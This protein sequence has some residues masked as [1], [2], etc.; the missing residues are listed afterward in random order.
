MRGYTFFHPVRSGKSTRLQKFFHRFFLWMLF[1][2]L[3][4]SGISQTGIPYYSNFRLPEGISEKNHGLVQDSVGN[5]LFANNHGLL[6]FDGRNWEYLFQDIVPYAIAG[7]PKS[8]R[9]YMS[10]K[11]GFGTLHKTPQESWSYRQ[12]Y[13]TDTE[14]SQITSITF[15]NDLVYFYSEMGIYR[16][17][18]L[19]G[20][21]DEIRPAPG[22]SFAGYF[23]FGDQLFVNLRGKGLFISKNNEL[24]PFPEGRLFDNVSI[25]FFLEMSNDQCILVTDNSMI[26]HFNG[27]VFSDFVP[28]DD[29]Y[30]SN[31]VITRGLKV[32]ESEISLATLSGGCLFLNLKTGK[33]D[34]IMNYQ[35]GLPDDEIY[36]MNMDRDKGIWLTHEFGATRIDPGLP[37]R[38][39]NPL[40]GLEG[41]LSEA[42]LFNNQLY[43]STGEGVFY[44]HR[45]KKYKETEIL[46][47]QPS[48]NL[49]LL[50]NQYKPVG[51]QTF[52]PGQSATIPPPDSFSGKKKKGFL[53]GIFKSGK[54]TLKRLPEKSS[55]KKA[56]T[57]VSPA[58]QTTIENQPPQKERIR[59]R[60]KKQ[61]KLVS[62]SWE[63]SK[64][65]ELNT[66]CGQM[67]VF[68][69]RLFVASNT[70]LYEITGRERKVITSYAYV[71]RLARS[72][73]LPDR[74]YV[75]TESGLEAVNFEGKTYRVDHDFLPLQQ[76]VFSI[77]EDG[78]NLWLG[79][80][81]KVIMVPLD[82]D[83]NPGE[84]VIYQLP[85]PFSERV[86]IKKLMNH[87]TFFIPS[88]VFTFNRNTNMVIA[89]DSLRPVNGR[90]N[91][92]LFAGRKGVFFRSEK[93]WKRLSAKQST[94]QVSP[95]LNLFGD[96][97]FLRP[98]PDNNLWVINGNNYLYKILLDTI[99]S[100]S[101]H[102]SLTIRSFTGSEKDFTGIPSPSVHPGDQP[103]VLQLNAPSYIRPD[104]TEYRF[105]ITG[106]NPD[107]SAWTA[108]PIITL[109]FLSSGSYVLKIRARNSLGQ[110]SRE[111]IIPLNVLPPFTESAYFYILLVIGV[112]SVIFLVVVIRERKLIHDKKVLELKVKARTR[113]IEMQ[114]EQ[115]E[116]Q[117]NKIEKQ[118]DEI[119]FRKQEITDSIS[120]GKRIQSAVLPPT[121]TLDKLLPGYFIFYQPRDIVSGDFYWILEKNGKVAV[122]VVDCT[123]H[124]VPGAFM[125]FLGYS[126]LTEIGNSD[127]L[128]NAGKILDQLRL[129][130]KAALH[131]T[132]ENQ[133]TEDG[134]D[135]ALCILD[136]KEKSCRFAGAYNSLYLV[137][138]QIRKV[139]PGDKM[140]IG[141]HM[142]D[143]QPFTNHKLTLE[144]GDMLY[145]FTDG[146]A[147]Q[148]GGP[149][150]KKFKIEPFHDLILQI[151]KLDIKEQEKR[152]DEKLREWMGDADQ[153]DDILVM[154][155]RV[156]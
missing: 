115:I 104:L 143:D 136:F 30:L 151:S 79:S 33:T 32:S 31:A 114:K 20:T 135:M 13:E 100:V 131:Q 99:H 95:Y 154:G 17:H 89:V 35:S 101:N 91:K 3:F 116:G 40:K 53:S 94:E 48:K 144:K 15:H 9:I 41:N 106:L 23:L 29:N 60:I 124:G 42:I 134:M 97:K 105:A 16:Y 27:H 46:I 28:Q 58:P 69:N 82:R 133:E 44:L 128:S 93:G 10:T 139:F 14:H 54:K 121:G 21:T 37:V 22:D 4:F 141:M 12:L 24:V 138:D 149:R 45:V 77:L 146:Y 18:P 103:L 127:P 102:F 84:P 147:D 86:T 50:K 71:N 43:V 38:T 126:I 119:A 123:G 90:L 122:A 156:K 5:L 155:I 1:S 80:Y 111:K 7:D 72:P 74:M 148:F 112:L 62:E 129:K 68:K 25:L 73:S 117:K 137:R 130:L 39:F 108:N 120:Y 47:K 2:G 107:W 109:P 63:F 11:T 113:E 125:S 145:M 26:Y 52:Q 57:T 96:I 55:K 150:G 56:V 51:R 8:G 81:S 34:F 140:P 118:R 64:V 110:Q 67:L 76:P 70:G 153:V 152:L 83:N 61:V 78:Q 85:S 36:A 59:Y 87:I 19:Q 66:K 98:G 75:G 65:Q 88:G 142:F 6:R 92:Y 132:S 49:P